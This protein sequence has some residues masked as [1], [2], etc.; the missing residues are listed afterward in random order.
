MQRFKLANG[1]K[2][3]L[4]IIKYFFF[5]LI[6]WIYLNAFN[7]IAHIQFILY[8]NSSINRDI[9]YIHPNESCHLI[10]RNGNG[11][12]YW[13]AKSALLMPFI[14]RMIWKLFSVC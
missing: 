6:M 1:F 8:L 14:P 10:P 3:F 4:N 11:K 13:D 2:D 5:N 12:E 9:L 7:S